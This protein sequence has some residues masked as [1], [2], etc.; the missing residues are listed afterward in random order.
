MIE[1]AIRFAV[2]AHE[3][4][5]RKG[6]DRPYILHPI[7]VMSIVAG[8]TEDEEV[9]AAAVLHDTVEDTAV[10][11]ADIELEF[12]PRVAKLVIAESED[13]MKGLPAGASW[14]LRK[15]PRRQAGQ[16]PGVKQGLRAA[17]GCALA[18]LQPEGQAYARLVLH[19]DL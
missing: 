3:G 19:I 11:A 7:E 16:Y 9:I 5:K 6:K 13:K 18:A 10:T 14:K 15:L 8:M 12:G 2:T 4:T 1:K 17:R